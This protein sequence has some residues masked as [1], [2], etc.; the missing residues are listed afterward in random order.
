M[1]DK[2]VRKM[3]TKKRFVA[4]GVFQA[5]LNQF[6]SR[7]LGMEGYAGIEVRL[8]SMGTEIRVRCAKA[9]DLLNKQAR[10]VKEIKALIE[11]RYNFNNEDN[12][13][14]LSIKPLAYD[15]NL[16]AAANAEILKFK[17]LSGTPV[18]LAANN[19][20][21][22][23]MRRGGAIGCEIIISGKI[24]GQRAKAQKYSAGYQISTG[25][26]KLDFIDRAVRNAELRSGVLGIQVKIMQGLEIGIGPNKKIL[27]DQVQIFEP[28]EEDSNITPTV[29]TSQQED[30]ATQQWAT[31]APSLA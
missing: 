16:C 12:K 7:T 30:P 6:L 11:K 9:T 13:V 22:T 27:P 23:V 28:K 2:K 19:I 8:T 1:A 21:G 20:I 25:Q 26:P 15:K 3:N 31:S 17:L 4:D 5:E 14:D 18:R 10:K 24:R 29:H